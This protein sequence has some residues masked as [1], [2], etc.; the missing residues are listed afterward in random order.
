MRVLHLIGI[1]DTNQVRVT[2]LSADPSRLAYECL[3]NVELLGLLDGSQ[4]DVTTLV[5]GNVRRDAV[6]MRRV[7]VVLNAICDADT[8]RASLR[9]ASQVVADAGVPVVNAPE[10]VLATT[11]DRVAAA[12]QGIPGVVVP[13][14]ARIVPSRVA[15]VEPLAAEASIA[16]PF[17]VREA[18]THGGHQLTLVADGEDLGALE[19][20]AFDGRSLYVTEFVD[21][22]SPDG[23]Y[24]KH[25]ALVIGGRAFAKHLIASDHWNV[26]AASRPF[27][28]ARPELVAEEEAF[29]AG[30]SEPVQETFERIHERLQLDYF[31]AD[32]ALT[33]DGRVV[34]FEVNACFRPLVGRSGESQVASHQASTAEVKR[35]M[36]DL[37]RSTA[38][39]G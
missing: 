11:R 38:A 19:R 2:H 15:E 23:I 6:T 39:R 25:R 14:T 29:V 33:D 28:A 37:L 30:L 32:F 12:L 34:V 9:A 1:D 35:A 22:R 24:R 18:G 4:F 16:R 10:R 26:H 17:L 20:F 3:G 8:N 7:D 5:C 13:R 21:F 27:M 31:G 36:A